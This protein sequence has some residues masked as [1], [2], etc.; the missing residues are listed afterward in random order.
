MDMIR[1]LLVLL[2][3]LCTSYAGESLRLLSYNLHHGEGTDGKVD[4][5]RIANYI[6]LQ[7]PD[8]VFLQEIDNICTRS[9]KVDQTAKLAKL[10]GMTQHFAKFMDFQGGEY[11]MALLTKLPVIE[12]RTV[13]L[14]AGDEPRSAAVMTVKTANGPLTVSSIHFYNTEAQRLA[15]AKTLV[16]GIGEKTPNIILMGDFNSEPTDSVMTWLA[17]RFQFPKKQGDTKFTWPS[18]VPR[19]NIDHILYRLAEPWKVKI[20]HVLDEKILSDHRPV[21][22]VLVRD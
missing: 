9:G 17:E 22:C 4:L 3:T 14:P 12:T 5:V 6:K 7:Q 13:T 20:Y 21:L 2:F 11:G 16:A 15:Q 19:E 18:D 10:T 1:A 8:I